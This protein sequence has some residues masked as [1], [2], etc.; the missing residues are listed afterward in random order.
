MTLIYGN[1]WTEQCSLTRD[2]HVTYKGRH[3]ADDEGG[4]CT[5]FYFV[6]DDVG[7][8]QAMLLLLFRKDVLPLA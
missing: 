7:N 6:D 1:G 3:F 4:Q 5:T 2:G 8:K